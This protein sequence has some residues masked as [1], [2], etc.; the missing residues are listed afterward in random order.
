[1]SSAIQL[2]IRDHSALKAGFSKVKSAKN[3]GQRIK[4]LENLT[5]RITVHSSVETNLFH[6][7]LQ[8]INPNLALIAEAS[9]KRLQ[10]EIDELKKIAP[11]DPSFATK[12]DGLEI[13]VQKHAETFEKGIFPVLSKELNGQDLEKMGEIYSKLHSITSTRPDMV[14]EFQSISLL[15]FVNQLRGEPLA[16]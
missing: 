1:M 7:A 9:H 4:A 3:M 5:N 8:K 10:K 11:I 13:Q 6:P 16:L 14:S 15:P 2:L 12:F